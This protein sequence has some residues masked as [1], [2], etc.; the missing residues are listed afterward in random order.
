MKKFD[1]IGA[2]KN[3]FEIESRVVLELSAQLNQSF[4][5]LCEDALS[6]NGKLIL[7][8]IGKSGHVCQKI[9]ATLSSTGTPSFFIHPTEAAHGDM[10]MI[11]KED[12]L[13]I[14]SNSGETQEIISILP[15]LK[16]TSK[17]LICVTGNNNS[18]IAKISD[19]AIEIK[20]SEEACTLDLAPTSSTT[21][22]RQLS[23]DAWPSARPTL[24]ALC[25]YLQCT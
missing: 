23:P 5:N 24:S 6:C 4:V 25:P 20:T 21:L 8:G 22:C 9:A 14:F 13:L 19:N 18:S 1:F 12:I 16:R 15:A 2:A 17:K 3:I 10:G 11:G 7:L